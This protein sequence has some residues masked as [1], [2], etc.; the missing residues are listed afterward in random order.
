MQVLV[1]TLFSSLGGILNVLVLILLVW[2]M[3]AILGVSL[4]SN[5]M[6]HCSLE[7]KNPYKIQE[8]E[9]CHDKGGVWESYPLNF[10]NLPN[11]MLSLLVI[12]SLNNWD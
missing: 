7:P 2:F 3:F 10:D 1:T 8:Y 6:I 11:G 5:Q 12:S 4:Y 9:S